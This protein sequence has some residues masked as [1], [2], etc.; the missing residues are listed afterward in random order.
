MGMF[1]S[2]THLLES[3]AKHPVNEKGHQGSEGTKR[4][5]ENAD[6]SQ[7]PDRIAACTRVCFCFCLHLY[8]FRIVRQLS[9]LLETLQQGKQQL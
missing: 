5:A 2:L 1:R 7:C 4:S 3:L 6:S 9:Q 8:V